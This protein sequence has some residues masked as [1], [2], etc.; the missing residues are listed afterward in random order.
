MQFELN[1]RNYETKHFSTPSKLQVGRHR[2]SDYV[3]SSLSSS[4][5]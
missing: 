1:H 3:A 4:P 2:L 5:A